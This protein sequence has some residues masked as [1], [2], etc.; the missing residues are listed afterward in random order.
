MHKFVIE[1]E[2]GGIFY[3]PTINHDESVDK[4]IKILEPLDKV[5]EVEL[6]MGGEDF[7]FYLLETKGAFIA[8][9]TRNEEKGLIH[10]HHHPKFDTDEEVYWKGTAIYALLGFANSF[11]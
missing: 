3:P 11:E 5:E 1:F 10:P 4:L 6:T 9:G 7:A 8:L 2:I